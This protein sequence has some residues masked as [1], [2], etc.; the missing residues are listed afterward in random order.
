[1]SANF[2]HEQQSGQTGRFS[3]AAHR[4]RSGGTVFTGPISPI[5]KELS[6]RPLIISSTMSTSSYRSR[7]T[8]LSTTA[9]GLE[10]LREEPSR[11]RAASFIGEAGFA[12]GVGG[13][14]RNFGLEGGMM[15][16]LV[17][18]ITSLA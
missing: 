14:G 16:S 6:L 3:N 2:H 18:T 12:R 1:M 17:P 9:R 15:I 10:M 11:A 4:W 8:R 5:V 7:D 13:S